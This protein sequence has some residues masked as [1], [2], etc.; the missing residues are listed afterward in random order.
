MAQDHLNSFLHVAEDL[1]VKGELFIQL[2]IED[3]VLQFILSG[4]TQNN[5]SGSEPDSTNP[6]SIS[7]AGPKSPHCLLPTE[8][9][10]SPSA[11]STLEPPKEDDCQIILPT[12][13]TEPDGTSNTTHHLEE[14]EQS[15]IMQQMQDNMM[16]QQL[17]DTIH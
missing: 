5:N 2:D 6:T 8:Y 15:M 13:K 14:Q 7:Q 1:R 10:T 3:N 11:K 9:G 4:L 16:E 17:Q 12:V